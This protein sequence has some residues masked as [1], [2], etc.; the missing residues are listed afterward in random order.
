MAAPTLKHLIAPAYEP[1]KRPPSA[2]WPKGKAQKKRRKRQ[3]KK[4]RPPP[5]AK[6]K[7]EAPAE[8]KSRGS[9]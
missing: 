2:Y 6:S 1:L 7:A 8:I 9:D 5:P 3:K 4:K